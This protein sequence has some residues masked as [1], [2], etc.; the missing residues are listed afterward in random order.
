MTTSL[1]LLTS[2]PDTS[3]EASGLLGHQGVKQRGEE[4]LEMMLPSAQRSN[5]ISPPF[6][7]PSS[8]RHEDWLQLRQ[9]FTMAVN[10]AAVP[11]ITMQ[12]PLDGYSHGDQ[13]EEREGEG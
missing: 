2:L 9:S 7:T 13:G 1:V 10:R 4:H 12:Y 6:C 3:Q 5:A 11:P 8:T